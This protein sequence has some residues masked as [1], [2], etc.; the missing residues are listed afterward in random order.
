MRSPVILLISLS[1]L[2]TAAHAYDNGM[3]RKPPMGWLSW[4]AFYCETDCEKHPNA[5]I[6]E[7]LYKGQAD[8]LVNEGYKDVGYEFM[9]VDDCW[10]EKERDPTTKRMVA[11]KIRFKSGMKALGDYLHGKGLKYGLYSDIGTKTCGGYPGELTEDGKTDYFDIDA[12]AYAEWG[13]DSLKVD[14]C[15]ID[16]K[17]MG[18]LYS[19]LSDSLNKTGRPILYYCSMPFFQAT[20]AGYKPEDIDFN[21]MRDK[22]QSWRF[23]NDINNSWASVRD[24]I[25]FWEKGVDVYSKY[26]GPFGWFDPDMVIVGC[27]GPNALTLNQATSQ[28]AFWSIMSAPLLL[29]NDLRTVKPEFKAIMQNKGMIAINQDDRGAMAKKVIGDNV[30]IWLKPLAAKNQFAVLYHNWD[31]GTHQSRRLSCPIEHIVR[32]AASAKVYD[33]IKEGEFLREVRR[34]AMLEFLMAPDSVA[35]AR[36]EVTPEAGKSESEVWKTGDVPKH[37]KSA[38]EPFPCFLTVE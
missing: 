28:F 7:E 34:G 2:L 20:T 35:F 37:E 14:G 5:C 22:C 11:D 29:S 23:Y 26:H 9:N 16:P 38:N 4:T 30:G 31:D 17:I 13:V 25:G 10:A 1:V 21:L 32:D 3:G 27:D 15:F 24:I 8:V 6:N 33:V 36:L 19:Q 12:K 18:P